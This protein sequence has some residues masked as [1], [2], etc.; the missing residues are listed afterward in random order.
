MATF[1]ALGLVAAACGGDAGGSQEGA[2]E[3]PTRNISFIVPAAPGGGA[4]TY[5][6]QIGN[7]MANQLETNLEIRNVP[8]AGTLLGV[9]EAA[10]ADADGYTLTTFNP[11]S[12][13]VSQI[14]AGE[15]AGVDIR[16][17]TFIGVM[18]FTSYVIY[19]RAD[20]PADDLE[21]AIAAADGAD[22]LAVGAQDTAGP[23]SLIWILIQDLYDWQWDETINYD[24]GGE[25]AAAVLRDEVPFGIT[26]DDSILSNVEGGEFKVLAA[27]SEE[28]SP[29]FPDVSTVTEL[30]YDSV[31]DLGQ[32]TR[33]VAGPPGIPP[34]IQSELAD[35]L[36]AA[37][38]DDPAI[39]EWAET[40]GSAIQ[41]AP[42]DEAQQI[43]EA[44][45]EIV[46]QIP[47]LETILSDG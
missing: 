7:A 10:R 37:I 13:T 14:A 4:D 32:L 2:E 30:G 29:L 9:G 1:A 24:G 44:S 40:T 41:F 45:F 23:S 25:L 6:R 38:E 36:Q 8:G 31:S 26:T 22:T 35:A 5:I 3:Y 28:R 20:N 39:A 11:P 19:T 15:S 12:A 47:N 43:T 42:P 33:L 27:L 16:D 46:E 21:A 34:D 18:G 17:M